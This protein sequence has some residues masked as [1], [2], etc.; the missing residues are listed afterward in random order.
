M[1]TTV[2]KRK[3]ET[4]RSACKKR[5]AKARPQEHEQTERPGAGDKCAREHEI[6]PSPKDASGRVW[7]RGP[8]VLVLTRGDLSRESEKEV[9]RSHSSEE[10]SVMEVERRAEEP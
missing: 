5:V 10:A 4:V 1:T 9:S 7:R 8:K 2:A 6:Q 3:G